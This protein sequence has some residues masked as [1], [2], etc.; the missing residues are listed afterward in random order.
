MDIISR[1]V[2][3][4]WQLELTAHPRSV[5]L[6]RRQVRAVLAE[7]GWNGERVDDVLTVCSE[8]V[9]NAVEHASQPGGV[10]MVRLQEIHGD[11]RLEV[12]DGRADLWPREHPAALGERGRGLL[13]VR[14]L[15]EDFGVVRQLRQ[16]RKTVWSR[17]LLGHPT[18]REPGAAA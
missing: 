5:G 3:R 11:C 8:L 4:R 9:A 1:A 18:D 15:S 12:V 14:L 13:L 2:L 10:V 7:W 17:L 16:C 6:A